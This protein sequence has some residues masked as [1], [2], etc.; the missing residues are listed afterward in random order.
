M[1]LNHMF[2]GNINHREMQTTYIGNI[3]EFDLINKEDCGM[4]FSDLIVILDSSNGLVKIKFHN[5]KELKV[6]SLSQMFQ[7]VLTINDIHTRCMEN[8]GFQVV[9]LEE[10]AI[11]FYC[12]RFEII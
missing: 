8:I 11:A 6:C 4:F 12:E 5:V 10:N 2:Q 1:K 9:E 7:I 3:V